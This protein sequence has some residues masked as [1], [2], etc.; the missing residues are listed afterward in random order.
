MG[1]VRGPLLFVVLA[2]GVVAA[3][4]GC[5]SSGKSAS[6]SS[7]VTSASTPSGSTT[8]TSTQS[9]ASSAPAQTSSSS[10]A[11]STATTSTT[12]SASATSSAAKPAL[13]MLALSSPA[14]KRGSKIPVRYTCDGANES[15]P[16]EWSNVPAKTAQLL[17][18]VL[19]LG[20]GPQGSVRWAVGDINPS[21][22]SIAANSVPAGAVVG[23][24]SLGK[25]NW[26]GV[27]PAKGK[28][29][30]YVFLLYALHKKLTLASGFP[31]TTVQ[32]Q[33]GSNIAGAGI[34]FGTYQRS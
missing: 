4:A 7:A 5:G 1:R 21:V 12:T 10:S 27:C 24:N 14:F 28:P 22:H 9:T 31:T 32:R 33:L 20:G 29:H 19:D 17:L 18:F 13:S 23:R 11:S 30:S 6:V 26:G 34:I 3:L 15:P 2:F 8:A 25:A 16:L